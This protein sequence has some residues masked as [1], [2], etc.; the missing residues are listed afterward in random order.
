MEEKSNELS[1]VD[2]DFN[3]QLDRQNQ[4]LEQ[5]GAWIKSGLLPPAVKTAEQAVVIALKGKEL[6]LES[7]LSFDL[8][9][10]IAG[11]PSLKPKGMGLLVRKGG[12]KYKTIK[13]FEPILDDKGNKVDYE[14]VIRFYRDGI[15]EDIKYTYKDA[16]LMGLTGKDNWK[17]QPGVMMY[18]RCFSKAANRVCPDLIGGMYTTEELT[19]FTPNSPQVNVTEDG[20]VE[21]IESKTTK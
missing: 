5:A 18:W 3:S 21:V 12:V 13:D 16:Q 10:V 15:E 6:G 19:S 17:K 2:R 20:D 14:T 7:M 1:K 11:K 8:I 9:D 4:L